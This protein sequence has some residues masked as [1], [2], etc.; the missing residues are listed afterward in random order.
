M[1]A[2]PDKFEFMILGPS[3]DN[4]FIFKMSWK[5]ETHL[6]WNYFD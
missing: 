2:N 4:C 1:K 5:L 6:K 3:D